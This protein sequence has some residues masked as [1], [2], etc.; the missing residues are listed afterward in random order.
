MFQ[1][2]YASLQ[3]PRNYGGVPT[4]SAARERSSVLHPISRVC[5]L[6]GIPAIGYQ[7][8][9]LYHPYDGTLE[10]VYVSTVPETNMVDFEINLVQKRETQVRELSTPKGI[11]LLTIS[12]IELSATATLI[13]G[14]VFVRIKSPVVSVNVL[15]TIHVLSTEIQQ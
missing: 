3:G 14:P 8:F 13:E 15:V 6:A 7:D 5:D 1:P 9:F 10:A 4:E 11:S 12:G 2:N